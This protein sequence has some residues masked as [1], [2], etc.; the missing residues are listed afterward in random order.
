MT[1]KTIRINNIF[2][3]NSKVINF[4]DEKQIC[5]YCNTY[6]DY[7]VHNCF[8][9]NAEAKSV[10]LTTHDRLQCYSLVIVSKRNFYEP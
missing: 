1:P 7:G 3:Y 5:D 2:P 8:S 9:L 6:T 10:F 4:N